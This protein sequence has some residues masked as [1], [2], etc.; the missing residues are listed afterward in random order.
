M[1]SFEIQKLTKKF[2]TADHQL[3]FVFSLTIR[4]DIFTRVAQENIK[5]FESQATPP[6]LEKS[7][8]KLKNRNA[9]INSLLVRLKELET[10]RI[11]AFL[12]K[13]FIFNDSIVR[14]HPLM[15][16]FLS[17]YDIEE[18]LNGENSDI[19]GLFLESKHA[20]TFFGQLLLSLKATI[21]ELS[22]EKI[23]VDEEKERQEALN[24]AKKTL[25]SD[26]KRKRE[27]HDLQLAET[28]PKN[29]PGQQ[30]RRQKWIQLY[31]DN[32]IHLKIQNET[33]PRRLY[34]SKTIE[35][36]PSE[37]LQHKPT[38]KTPAQAA[39]PHMRRENNLV[40][41]QLHPSWE[42]KRKQKELIAS[43]IKGTK[44][45]FGE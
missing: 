36:R 7:L 23:T 32:A 43:G 12:L 40:P 44:I 21:T 38:Y 15:K 41:E 29:R 30:A 45:V 28:K 27:S 17:D 5:S 3:K 8:H 19:Q 14:E 25:K 22:K 35:K 34:S 2:K 20:A 13:N 33:A 16:P 39:A 24:N 26:K 10:E 18:I 31:G 11:C 37:N 6:K 1:A 4:F 9:R 42:A